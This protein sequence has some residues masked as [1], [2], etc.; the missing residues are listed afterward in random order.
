MT[1]LI[2]LLLSGPLK[3]NM[4]NANDLASS[5]ML[6][7][8]FRLYSNAV[9]NGRSTRMTKTPPDCSECIS[10]HHGGC[11]GG[12]SPLLQCD[13]GVPHTPTATAELNLNVLCLSPPAQHGP[14]AVLPQTDGEF[15]AG[16]S[17][18]PPKTAGLWDICNAELYI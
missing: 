18:A 5:F 9:A 16:V 17:S 12:A 8:V 7:F 3:R 14:A 2:Y 11:G 10:A 15:L 4:S 6:C 13:G 1:N